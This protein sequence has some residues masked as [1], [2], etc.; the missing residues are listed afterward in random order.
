M[1]NKYYR[2]PISSTDREEIRYFLFKFANLQEG[3]FHVFKAYR[4][5]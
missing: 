4:Q 3:Y 5:Y 1:V 2:V